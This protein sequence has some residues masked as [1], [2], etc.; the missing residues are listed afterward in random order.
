MGQL[1]AALA[2]FTIITNVDPYD[3][4]PK[5]ILSDIAEAALA[6]GGQLEKN[7]F[8]IEDRRAGIKQA[9]TLAKPGDLVLITGKGAEQSM[10]IG[11]RSVPWDDRQVVREE[12]GKML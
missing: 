11:G 6:H 5:P 4:D 12:L 3:D 7:V 1:C 10:E 2:D 8:V 9:L